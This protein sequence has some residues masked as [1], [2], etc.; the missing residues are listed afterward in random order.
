[1]CR[2]EFRGLQGLK[3]ISGG[4]L[5]CAGRMAMVGSAVDTHAVRAAFDAQIRRNTT[6]LPSSARG[7]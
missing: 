4:Y 6:R 1:M 7:G 3:G 2:A 5:S